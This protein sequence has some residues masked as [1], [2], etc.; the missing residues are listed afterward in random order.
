MGLFSRKDTELLPE[1]PAIVPRAGGAA[2]RWLGRTLLRLSGWR[3]EGEFPHH[4]QMVLAAAPH[5]SNWDFV[6]AMFVIMALGV[7][8]SYMMKKEAFFWP[9]GA[10]F[11]KLGGIPIDRKAATD[12]V[13]QVTQWY[14]DHEKVWVVITP[15][16]TRAKVSR[17]KTG[18]L[19][20]AD[21]AKVPVCL[22]AW[23]YPSKTMHIGP[24]WPVSGDYEADL[25]SIREYICTRYTGQNPENQ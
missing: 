8:V 22:V 16:G 21:S 24:V 13:E 20:I 3:L 5:T 9:F 14:R 11:M 19:R 18:F 15:E 4:R 10:L 23:D 1:M 17:W 7:R 6:I 25:A 2:R 12:V